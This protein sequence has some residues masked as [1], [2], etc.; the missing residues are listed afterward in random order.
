MITRNQ[1]KNDVGKVYIGD[2]RDYSSVERAMRGVD[3]VFHVA[4]LKQVPSCIPIKLQ[5]NKCVWHAKRN[6]PQEL[7]R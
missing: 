7:T 3:Y 6:R 4:A 2:V 1:L 5:K